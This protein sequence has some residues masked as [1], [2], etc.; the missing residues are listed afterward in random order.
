VRL[1][2]NVG[3]HSIGVIAKH[4]VHRCQP[5]SEVRWSIQNPDRIPV[6]LPRSS[7]NFQ[8]VRVDDDVM[9]RRARQEGVDDVR[10]ERTIAEGPVVLAW[11]ALG[12]MS[13]WDESC[14][15]HWVC[16]PIRVKT[17]VAVALE[18]AR[19]IEKQTGHQQS[20]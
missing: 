10:V 3:V 15:P 9:D 13:H 17:G 20:A 2:K 18:F 16:F 19:R 14:K 1:Q 11:H 6:A 7:D 4:I 5:A 8:A 12:L